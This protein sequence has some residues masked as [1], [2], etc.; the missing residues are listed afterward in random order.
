MFCRPP[1][2]SCLVVLGALVSLPDSKLSRGCSALCNTCV[3]PPVSVS[4]PQLVRKYRCFPAEYHV[5]GS[6]LL[7]E[8][9][10]AFA[11]FIFT[12]LRPGSLRANHSARSRYVPDATCARRVYAR[13]HAARSSERR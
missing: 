11:I 4:H 7:C 3:I 10:H 1:I 5:Y 6:F 13:R 12:F 9:L 8:V 2:C